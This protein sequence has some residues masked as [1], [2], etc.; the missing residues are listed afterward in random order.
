VT[1]LPA[2]PLVAALAFTL[3]AIGASF[4][5]TAAMR[6]LVGES[7]ILGRSYCEGCRAELPFAATV[8]IVSFLV[9]R[10]RC[11]RC[12]SA[13]S[14]I[15]PASELAGG[16]ALSLT[17]LLVPPIV[18]APLTFT[19]MLLV[20][21]AVVDIRSLRIPDL[22]VLGVAISGGLVASSSGELGDALAT[23]GATGGVLTLVAML[24][25]RI[26]GRP[27]LGFG[28]VKLLAALSI[29]TGPSLTPIALV[30]SCAAGLA[31]THLAPS[32]QPDR[33]VPFGPFIAA[34]FWP[35]AL[36]RLA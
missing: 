34:V 28:D 33:R 35:F 7:A 25:E 36:G 3:G 31:W 6:G 17:A 13:I 26:R 18:W 2:S 11:S 22:A 10:G 4:A 12:N 1:P 5:S 14:L 15:H 21:A 29:W 30:L 19:A 23:G 24:F 16:L 20:Y 32:D 8:P 9:R 27:G